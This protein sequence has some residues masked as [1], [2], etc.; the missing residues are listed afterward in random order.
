[1]FA[2]QRGLSGVVNADA[3][4]KDVGREAVQ[5]RSDLDGREYA[6]VAMHRT[7]RFVDDED[8]YRSQFEIKRWWSTIPSLRQ[9][10]SKCRDPDQRKSKIAKTAQNPDIVPLSAP[11]NATGLHTLFVIAA[12][13]NA[14][15]LPPISDR[16]GVRLPP[17]QHCLT[18]VN[19]GIVPNPPPE[20]FDDF[21]EPQ[22]ARSSTAAAAAASQTGTTATAAGASQS[23]QADTQAS[24]LFDSAPTRTGVHGDDEDYDDDNDD[25]EDP[26]DGDV[27]MTT[28]HPSQSQ[29]TAE[30]QPEAKD[31]EQQEAARG[32]KRSLDEDEEYD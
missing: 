2:N 14:I 9:T 8:E 29:P 26:D 25:E 24:T 4:R 10:E 17:A 32:V 12:E 11:N 28:V 21:E 7:E 18:N 23:T 30:S 31:S 13:V 3:G 15:P 5:Q 16:H 20:D 27:S 22:P 6:V 19:F 1:M